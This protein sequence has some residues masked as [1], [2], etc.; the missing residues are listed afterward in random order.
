M[1]GFTWTVNGKQRQEQ[2]QA[3]RASVVQAAAVGLHHYF[4][5]DKLNLQTPVL[6]EFHDKFAGT[7][8]ATVEEA[9]RWALS[10][11]GTHALELEGIAIY[12]LENLARKL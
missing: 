10:P 6:I 11:D 7:G 12:S 3:E 5:E 9:L 4:D 1:S 8:T 2:L